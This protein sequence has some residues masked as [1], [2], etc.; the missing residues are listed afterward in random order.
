MQTLKIK[1]IIQTLEFRDFARFYHL[2][3]MV[4]KQLHIKQMWA[5]KQHTLYLIII[6]QRKGHPLHDL[7][8]QNKRIEHK[9]RLTIE[10]S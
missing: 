8:N 10:F 4:N 1:F 5:L 2:S 7:L 3:L 9:I 6:I